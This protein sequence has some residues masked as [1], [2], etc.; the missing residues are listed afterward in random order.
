M[1]RL[2]RIGRGRKRAAAGQ[3]VEVVSVQPPKLFFDG[4]GMEIPEGACREYHSCDLLYDLPE[5]D[6][7]E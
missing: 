1:I 6:T 2:A 5:P 4:F 7:S 3:L